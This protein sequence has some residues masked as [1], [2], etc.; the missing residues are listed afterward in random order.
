MST[1]ATLD[2]LRGCYPQP[3][4]R[5]LR[6]SLPKLDAH[7]RRFIGLSPFL[8]L[9]TS[10]TGGADVT[11]RGDSPGFVHVLDDQTLLI[12]DWPGN[13]RLDSLTNVVTNANV[14]LLFLIP[15]VNETLRVNGVAEVIMEPALLE[16]WTVNGKHPRSAMRVTVREAYLHCA[17]ALMRSKLWNDDYRVE[18]TEL[19]TYAQ[20]LK[21]QGVTTQS[22][23]ELQ[24]SIDDS[25]ATRLY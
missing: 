12:P 23:E 1:I 22:I 9:G 7:M 24:A 3:L 4:E 6:K 10:G 11:P 21:D 2:E 18:R 8:C 5:S 17:K 20:M 19:P 25:Y 13:N 14:G 16:R 15:G